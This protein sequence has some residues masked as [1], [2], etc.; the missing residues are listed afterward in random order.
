MNGQSGWLACEGD[1]V[2]WRHRQSRDDQMSVQ[3]GTPWYCGED[4]PPDPSAQG[5]RHVPHGVLQ[6]NAIGNN[7]RAFRKLRNVVEKS[8]AS[9]PSAA[10]HLV[11]ERDESACTHAGAAVLV[12]FKLVL[13]LSS[14]TYITSCVL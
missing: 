2:I 10:K 6:E 5:C 8:K 4:L 7:P 14:R 13:P 3:A 9:R 11:A 12:P 1:Q